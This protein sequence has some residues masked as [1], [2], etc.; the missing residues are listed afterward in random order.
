MAEATCPECG[1]GFDSDQGLRVHYGY[2]HDDPPPWKDTG[3]EFEC[4]ECGDAFDT[5]SG[6]AT[7]YGHKH[8]GSPPWEPDETVGEFECSQ[9]EKAFDS[10][11]A[12]RIHRT[13]I[14]TTRE[15]LLDALRELGEGTPPTAKQVRESGPFGASTYIGEFG[16]WIAALEAAGYD[17]VDNQRQN[18]PKPDLLAELRRVGGD[19]P[20]TKK[21]MAERGRYSSGP[22]SD[23]FGS[24]G[25]ALRTAG[26]ELSPRQRNNIPDDELLAELQHVAGDNPPTH[27]EMERNGRYWAGTYRE[28]F[29]SWTAALRAAGYE[30]RIDQRHQIGDD[31]LLAEIRGLAGD[32]PP[33]AHKMRADGAHNPSTYRVHFGSWHD[34]IKAAGYDPR[35]KR[36]PSGPPLV[37]EGN[38]SRQRERAK[39]RDQCRCQDCGATDGEHHAEYGRGLD[40]HHKT[41]YREF[42]DPEQAN[43]LSNLVTL[44]R[45]CHNRRHQGA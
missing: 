9:C 10:Q 32:D 37:Y 6:R 41:P 27:A 24:W 29:G 16:S 8:D 22:Y 3:G 35:R 17:P 21:E 38:W 19:S 20:P 39:R 1:D 44:C 7:H 30:P 28:R 4:P 25:A 40:V 26:Y 15:N 13:K 18:I 14:H 31:E 11:R 5:E 36:E 45:R 23:R 34:A 43:E 33:T 12:V 2:E 42:D